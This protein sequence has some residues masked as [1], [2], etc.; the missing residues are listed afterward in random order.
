[1]SVNPVTRRAPYSTAVMKQSVTFQ[2]EE[3]K[4]YIGT[5]I[6]NISVALFTLDVISRKR[7]ARLK[8]STKEHKAAT[9]ALNKLFTDFETEIK[10]D[11]TRLE[12]VLKSQKVNGRAEHN[13]PRSAQIEITTPELKRALDLLIAFDNLIVLVDTVWLMGIMETDEA[14]QFRLAKSRQLTNLF[15]N[16]YKLSQAAKKSSFA[17]EDPE[18]LEQ[19][20]N[21][22]QKHEPEEALEEPAVSIDKPEPVEAEKAETAVA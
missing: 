12:A 13:N 4:N 9:K 6:N 14:N 7:I 10:D 2:T 16:I 11:S 18:V 20:A 3:A 22:E 15:K 19:I 21:E 8:L 1:M 5:W 17:Q